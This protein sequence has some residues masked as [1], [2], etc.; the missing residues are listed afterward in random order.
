MLT[1]RRLDDS[2]NGAGAA[3]R[4]GGLNEMIAEPTTLKASMERTAA[5]PE[6][7]FDTVT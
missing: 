6:M 7:T 4:P 1:V 2:G 5:R 3:D